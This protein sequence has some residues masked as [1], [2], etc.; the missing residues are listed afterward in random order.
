MSKSLEI[1]KQFSGTAAK[2]ERAFGG[3]HYGLLGPGTILGLGFQAV[4]AL[5]KL[6]ENR[7]D[8]VTVNKYLNAQK[9]HL[10]LHDYESIADRNGMPNVQGQEWR[11]HRKDKEWLLSPGQYRAFLRNAELVY[12]TGKLELGRGRDT[13]M[14]QTVWLNAQRFRGIHEMEKMVEVPKV[15]AVPYIA[16]L[17][18]RTMELMANVEGG[19]SPL[20]I[21]YEHFARD[22]RQLEGDA[23]RGS[24]G[25]VSNWL[26][27]ELILVSNEV[28]SFDP[29]IGE[30]GRSF[31]L[32]D[33]SNP[34]HM[35]RASQQIFAA[36]YLNAARRRDPEL[37]GLMSDVAVCGWGMLCAGQEYYKDESVTEDLLKGQWGMGDLKDNPA[38]IRFDPEKWNNAVD[39]LI[40]DVPG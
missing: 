35:G 8:P 7:G 11:T 1:V 33:P 37:A 34:A 36:N 28:S 18:F 40:K 14:R 32:L 5:E 23:N 2:V 30:C 31:Y 6:G 29:T 39:I 17:A 19:N 38:E 21:I 3:K 4:G 25:Y 27:E 24:I 15:W 16:T 22:M 26:A 9:L 12:E 20:S 10:A 13:A